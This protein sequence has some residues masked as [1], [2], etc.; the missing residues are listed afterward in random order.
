MNDRL[1]VESLSTKSKDLAKFQNVSTNE[2]SSV[3]NIDAQSEMKQTDEYFSC[4][5]PFCFEDGARKEREACDYSIRITLD[6]VHQG[7]TPR[8]IRI[9]AIGKIS[10]VVEFH[11]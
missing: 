7:K 10:R 5:A 11:T 2:N 6:M 8:K 9:L 3:E 1:N 4:P